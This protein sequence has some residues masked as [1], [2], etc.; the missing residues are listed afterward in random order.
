[1][2]D[3]SPPFGRPAPHDGADA[4][5]TSQPSAPSGGLTYRPPVAAPSQDAPVGAT[6]VKRAASTPLTEHYVAVTLGN[7]PVGQRSFAEPALRA[8]IEDE[9]T[10][11]YSELLGEENVTRD[12]IEVAVLEDMGD[13]EQVAA[14]MTHRPKVLVG[15]RFYLDFKHILLWA[16]ALVVPVAAALAFESAGQDGAE[17]WSS[18]LHGA[19][20]ALTAAAYTAAWVTIGF[21]VAERVA[22]HRAEVASAEWTV[23]HLPAPSRTVISVGQTATAVASSLVVASAIVI[24]QLDPSVF[25]A[26]GEPITFLNP[27]N[28]PWALSTVVALLGVNVLVAIGRHVRGF[29]SMRSAVINLALLTAIYGLFAWMLLQ[30]SFLNDALFTHVGWPSDNLPPATLESWGAIA[31]G[32]LWLVGVGIGFLRAWRARE[33]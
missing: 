22:R 15:A 3:Q 24:Q 10:E 4:R 16:L 21:A 12:D 13:P 5:P 32:V 18:I 19:A 23:D 27:G 29:W 14:A 17:L 2:T 28:W 8:A 33:A 9:I 26:Q 31:V 20:V 30:H 1:M 6:P 11:R 25:T 7:V